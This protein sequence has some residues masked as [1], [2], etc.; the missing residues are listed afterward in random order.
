MARVISRFP[1]YQTKRETIS[2]KGL[3]FEQLTARILRYLDEITDNRL[4]NTVMKIEFFIEMLSKHE[5]NYVIAR[6][7]ET[8]RTQG[9]RWLREAFLQWL[10]LYS[11]AEKLHQQEETI[12]LKAAVGGYLHRFTS[13]QKK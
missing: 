5:T 13:S 1:P 3:D 8:I 12:F 11:K 2:F 10:R 6:A 4:V 9:I 7:S